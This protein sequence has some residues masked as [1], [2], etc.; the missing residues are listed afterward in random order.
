MGFSVTGYVLE[1]PRVGQ[2]NSSFTFTPNIVISNQGLFNIA[3]PSDESAPRTDYLVFPRV[4]GDLPDVL[5]CWTKNEVI[6]RFDYDGKNQRFKLLPGSAPTLVGTLRSDANTNRLKVKAPGSTNFAL[7][8]IRLWHGSGSGI[9]FTIATVADD[10]GFGFPPPGIVELSLATGNLNW[11]ILDIPAYLGQEIHYQQQTFFTFAESNGRLGAIEDVLVLNPMPATG[12]FPLIRIGFGTYLTPIEK[13]TEGAF[14]ADPAAGTVEWAL[15][16]GRLKFSSTDATTYAGSYVYYDGVCFAFSLQLVPFLLGT[17]AA[18]GTIVSVPS[19]DADTFFRVPGV[20]QFEETVIVDTLSTFGKKNQVEIRRSDGL[21]Q[22]SLADRAAYGPYAVQAIV[23]DLPIERGISLRLF[24]TPVDPGATDVTL[25]DISA[26]YATTGAILADPVIGAP[27]VSLPAV[28]VESATIIVQVEQRTGSFVGTLPR[29]DV[30]SPPTGYGYVLDFEAQELRFARRKENIVIAGSAQR[31]YGAVQLPDTVIRSSNLVLELETAPGSGI[32]APLTLNETAL[33]DYNSGLAT[34]VSTTGEIMASGSTGAF[35]G[36]GTTFTDAAQDFTAL[37]VISGDFLVVLSGV[38]IGIYTIDTVTGS[39]LTTDLAGSFEGSLSYEIRRTREVLADRYFKAISPLDPNTRVERLIDLGPATNSPRLSIPADRVSISRIRLGKTVFATSNAVVDDTF[40]TAPGTLPPGTVEM[41]SDTGHLNFSTADLGK[42]AYWS[43]TLTL[44]TDYQVQPQLSFI[45]FSERM[46][47][48]E[49]VFVTYAV[50]DADGNRVVVEERGAFDVRKEVTAAHPTPTTTLFFNPLGREVAAAPSARAFRGG[51]PQVTGQQVT[52]DLAA[53]A[54]T[55]LPRKTGEVQDALPAGQTVQP[56]ERVYVDYFIHGAIGGEN[57]LTLLQTPMLG[58]TISITEGETSFQMVGDRR[59]NFPAGYLIRVDNSEVYL[60]AAPSYDAPSDITTINLASP[61]AFR[62]DFRNPSLAV[63]SGRTRVNASF[64]LPSYFVTEFT[65]Y[66]TPPRGA[67]KIKFVGDIS[68]VYTSGIVIHW[69][70]GAS[71]FDFN[72]VEGSVFNSDTNRTEVTLA[73]NGAR[74]YTP[75]LVTLKRSSKPILPSNVAVASTAM[76]PTLSLPYQVYR[77][78]EGS[79]GQL[80]ASPDDYAIDQSGRVS[81]AAPMQDNEE[82]SI[83]YT[84]ATIVD[85]GRDFRASYTHLV[86]PDTTNGL[87]GQTLTMDFTTYAPDTFYWR[88]ETITA[89][90][91]ELAQKYNADAQATI[92]TGG[93]RLE[94]G[95]A[96]KLF[97]QGRESLYFQEGHLANEDL[98][99]RATLKFYNDGTNLL[100]DT[101]RSMDGRVIGDH[102]GRFLFDGNIDN[103]VR[104]AVVDVTNQIDDVLRIFEGPPIVTFPPLAVSFAGT[105][106]AMYLPSKYS[107][108]FPTKRSLYGV[109]ADPT[110]LVTGDTI[111]DLQFKNLSA[112]NQIRRRQPWAVVTQAAP[113]GSLVLQV[114]SADGALDLLRPAFDT[115]TFDHKVAIVAQDGTVLVSELSSVQLSSKTATSLTFMAPLPMPIPVGAT[116][117]QVLFD[118]FPPAAPYPKFYRL[119]F[120]VGANLEEGALFHI[121]AYPPFD[122]TFP[123]IPVELVIANPA[124]GEVLDV[125]CDLFNTLVEPFRFPALDGG[126]QDDDRN[127]QFPILSPSLDSEGGLSLG[128]VYREKAV[129]QSAT[130]TL[131]TATTAPFVGTG[132]LTEPRITITN[133][134]G[135]WPAPIPKVND[136]VE[137]RTGFNALSGYHLITAVGGSS[138]TVAQPFSFADIGFT[139]TVTVANTLVTGAAGLFNPATRLTDGLADFVAA[140]VQVGHT[141][142]VTS[143]VYTGLRR[144]VTAVVSTTELDIVALPGIVAASY[145][146]DNPLGTFGGAGSVLDAE[147]VPDVAGELAVLD[148]NAPP[149]KP[150]SERTGIENFFDH[151]FTDIVTGTTGETFSSATF[152]DTAAD[153]VA[154]GVNASHFVYIRSGIEAGV[155]QV[156]TVN[157]PTSLDITELFPGTTSGITYR[158]VDSGG[159]PLKALQDV[160]DILQAIDQAIVDTTA[161]YDLITTAVPVV[162]DASAFG[163]RTLTSDLNTREAQVNARITAVTDPGTGEAVILSSTL[164]STAKLYDKRYVWIDARINLEKGILTKQRRAVSDR[165]KAEAEILK[166]L[167]KLLT[168]QP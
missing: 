60:L 118:L 46:L 159:L 126:T 1:P 133:T 42:T 5:F 108:F 52:F 14:S 166:Q 161:F 123:G 111:A 7:F 49:E 6:N 29:L 81:F 63:T 138:I 59:V 101:L 88:V 27:M 109:T 106:Q 142:V 92:P 33:F 36:A 162:G 28:P 32:F 120:D 48:R 91:V 30:P 13:A 12:Q 93:P 79:V 99:A 156:A 77:R 105:F 37:G 31:P 153:F 149:T 129:I 43:R 40:F 56:T 38:S 134:G 98:V 132:K 45:Q 137:I 16:T 140:G 75:G 163:R 110:G 4:D 8:P 39:V 116:V 165:Q 127:R 2:A 84:G 61:Q 152:S 154:S 55:F 125:D 131:R 71:I 113:A 135:V 90:R 160:F 86:V 82:L 57:T 70:D 139:F 94:N 53:S 11:N 96:P 24:R 80:L 62:S 51:R 103:P 143:G 20:V 69:T 102:D 145:R 68:R 76:S 117:Y 124:A 114:D 47:E 115:T 141:V 128:Y 150:Y 34:L 17:V 44:G 158:I 15:A 65:A 151:F 54:M 66:E 22:F 41:S 100:E 164:A 10:S 18:P 35:S 87:A 168:T 97:E 107:R 157:S 112:V 144:Q 167:T 95:S 67:S 89:F 148:T 121:Q 155:Y 9:A 64:L 21:V 23:P 146:V 26:F 119:Y 72:I 122:G 73:S 130:G 50:L 25:K 136:L 104:S 3:Y 83:F 19:P 147:L 58:V 78:V 74:Q 85:D